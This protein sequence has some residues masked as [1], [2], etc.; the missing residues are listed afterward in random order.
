MSR[1][2]RDGALAAGAAGA[3]HFD[4]VWRGLADPEV[5]SLTGTRHTFSEEAIRRHLE[6]IPNRTDWADWAIVRRADDVMLGEVVLNELD[7]DYRSMNFHITLAG[8]DVLGQEYGTEAT[9]AVVEYG[10]EVVGLHRIGPEVYAFHPRP[11]GPREGG[12][13]SRGRAAG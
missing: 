9:R 5:R 10:L 1:N 2:D 7:T 4:G 11:A 13:H 6:L 12:L 8:A 3:G